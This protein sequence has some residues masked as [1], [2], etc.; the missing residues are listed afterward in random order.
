VLAGYWW[1]QAVEAGTT[2]PLRSGLRA[3]RK[4]YQFF[5]YS[6]NGAGP[7]L[8]RAQAED[9]WLR[10]KPAG[11]PGLLALGGVGLALAWRRTAAQLAVVL[12]ALAAAGAILWHPTAEARAPVAVM[13]ALLG[14]GVLAGRWPREW[15]LRLGLGALAVGLLA[16]AWL[17]RPRDPAAALMAWDARKRALAWAELG[18]YDAA[19]Q[20]LARNDAANGPS[21]I[22]RE[23]AEEW[24]FARMLKK[25]P[26]LP[27]KE[28][29]EAQLLGNAAAAPQSPAA[30]YRCGACLWLLG[31]HDGALFYWRGLA[32]EDGD[33]GEAAREAIAASGE[34]TADEELRRE[35]WELDGNSPLD[36]MLAP[37]LKYLRTG[38][39]SVAK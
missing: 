21:T 4:V 9:A 24:R 18:D 39:A 19:I 22:G 2:W 5:H 38:P 29:L 17:P 11:W 31:Q 32:G 13:L 34:E 23:M 33:W 30:Q 20:E 12:A 36:S 8:A 7:D 25:L 26:A 16:F 14:G 15:K 27:V 10:D 37:L 6:N 1:R 3:A 28:E 35:A